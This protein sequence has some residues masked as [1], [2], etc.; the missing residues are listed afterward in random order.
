M[1]VRTNAL[2][3][4]VEVWDVYI[5]EVYV[6]VGPVTVVIAVCRYTE[7]WRNCE[8]YAEASN[9]FVL[10]SISFEIVSSSKIED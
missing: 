10:L 1:E 9:D 2:F 8:Q 5:L 4:V 7:G 3:V 6:I